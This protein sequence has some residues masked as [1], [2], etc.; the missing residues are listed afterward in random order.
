MSVLADEFVKLVTKG[1]WHLSRG[2]FIAK[3]STG[4]NGRRDE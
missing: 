3:W 1:T 2:E 4:L